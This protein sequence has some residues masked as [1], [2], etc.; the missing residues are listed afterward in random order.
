MYMNS[1]FLRL[2]KSSMF[3]PLILTQP[4]SGLNSPT[5][6]SSRLVL[7]A[8]LF[9]MKV[10]ISGLLTFNPKFLNTI[11]LFLDKFIDIICKIMKI[12]IFN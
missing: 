2:P 6:V 1:V 11:F 8:P 9:P 3:T 7:P 4:L 12:V 10:I 5:I